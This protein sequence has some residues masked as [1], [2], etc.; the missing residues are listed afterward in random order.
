MRQWYGPPIAIANVPGAVYARKDGE[1]VGPILGGGF[2]GLADFYGDRA[3]RIAR[4][5]TKRQL[6]TANSG[7]SS[8]SDL[9]SEVTAG[10]G[11]TLSFAKNDAAT[12]VHNRTL[13]AESGLPSAGATPAA[14]PGGEIPSNATTGGFLQWDPNGTDT[15]HLT[16][17]AL[18]SSTGANIIVLY[19]RLFAA[20]AVAHT[21][22]ASQ[23][24]TGTPTRYNTTASAPGN[25][26][27]LEVTDT[28]G[29]TAHTVLIN[30]TD[31]SN[32]SAENSGTTSIVVSSTANRIPHAQ[33]F[34]PLNVNDT[35]LL[36]VTALTF[37]AVSSGTSNAVIGHPLTFIPAYGG[38][39]TTVLHGI[40]SAFNLAEIETDACL[41]FLALKGFAGNTLYFGSIQLV[42][43]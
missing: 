19:D 37:S 39:S 14:R 6:R 21:N 5:F 13:W 16:T 31:N 11:Q 38:N 4:N 1:F 40:N 36:A 30:Y 24:V 26:F 43:G 22:N 35:G 42:S 20:S 3:K 25:F 9:L 28:L 34:I 41:A 12:A 18:S 32:N 33:F 10:K 23:T 29:A 27:F 7:F 8:L 15:L 2:A 17:I